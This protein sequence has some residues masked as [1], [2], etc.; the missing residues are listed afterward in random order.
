MSNKETINLDFPLSIADVE[1]VEETDS[2][3]KILSQLLFCVINGFIIKR[4]I[5]SRRNDCLPVEG[6]PDLSIC[7]LCGHLTMETVLQVINF[8]SC[9]L[10]CVSVEFI[11]AYFGIFVFLNNFSYHLDYLHEILIMII[12]KLIFCATK[13]VSC[14]DWI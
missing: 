11:I 14:I 13:C 2:V 10:K 4:Y 5:T 7:L 9:T 1:E 12:L 8:L 6:F 3:R